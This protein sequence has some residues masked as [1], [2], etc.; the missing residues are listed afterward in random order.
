MEIGV[1][2]RKNQYY[3]S[4]FLM[5]INNNISA[6]EGV[7]TSAVLMGTE[8]NKQLLSGI[9]VDD[10]QIEDA[11]P[12]DLIVAVIADRSEIVQT[13]LGDLDNWFDRGYEQEGQLQPKTLEDGLLHKPN[14]NLVVISVPGNHAFREAKKALD[15]GINVFLFSDNVPIAEELALK[16]YA[17]ANGLMVMGPDCGTSIIAGVGIGFANNVRKGSIGVVGASGTGLQEFTC[18]I[19]NSGF[20]ISH[21]IGTG[22]HDLSDEVGGIT[23]L[24]GLKALEKDST[25]RVIVII[26]KPPGLKTLE[27]IVEIVDSF[28]KPVIGCF[29]GLKQNLHHE[30]HSI[31]LARNVDK[32][33]I[34][35][36]SAMGERVAGLE[37]EL[38]AAELKLLE[39]EKNQLASSQKYGRGIFAGG[40]FCYQAQQIFQD[41]GLKV[42]SNTPINKQWILSAPDIS[43]EHTMID[44]GDD[45][46]TVDKP[47]PMIDGSHRRRRIIEESKD[48]LVAVLLIDIILGYNASP[49]PVGDIIDAIIEA[50]QL[51][52]NRGQHLCV[53][54]S[55]CGTNE[56]HQDKEFQVEKLERA[57]VIVLKSNAKAALFCSR[58]WR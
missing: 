31:I 29:L 12:N 53:V 23:T 21:A 38:S 22:S 46:Y 9:G 13:I 33:V 34:S 40:T 27:R 49:D 39:I 26:S 36:I 50:K 8:S 2:I 32:A 24:A 7:K 56:D 20:G 35:A 55:V 57:G 3:D 37:S 43:K 58:L 15:K 10:R 28:R 14:A 42:Y 54:A 5:G 45:C 17:S 41:F 16:E 30:N 19:H 1:T 4:V 47:H 44:M 48:P 11:N 18:Q 52:K 6:I 51:A 25:T